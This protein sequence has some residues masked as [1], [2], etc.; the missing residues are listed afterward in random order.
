MVTA[1]GTYAELSRKHPNAPVI[2]TGNEVLLPGIVN[3]HHDVGLN[4]VQLG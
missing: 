1:I 2:G 4:T 3:G